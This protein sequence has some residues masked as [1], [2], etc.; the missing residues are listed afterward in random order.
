MKRIF[1]LLLLLHSALYCQEVST[2]QSNITSIEDYAINIENSSL[3]QKMQIES[4]QQQ[5]KNAKE[6]QEALE[7]SVIEISAQAKELLKSQKNLERRCMSLKIAL[8]VSA[9]LSIISTGIMSLIL[10]NNSK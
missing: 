1:F 9:S 3:Q 2:I 5:L 6:S 10:V 7:N 8:G 4:L